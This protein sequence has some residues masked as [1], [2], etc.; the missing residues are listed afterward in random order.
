MLIKEDYPFWR[1][2]H[3]NGFVSANWNWPLT[4]QAAFI[5]GT[6]ECRATT[7]NIVDNKSFNMV[8]MFLSTSDNSIKKTS[9][10][11]TVSPPP[12]HR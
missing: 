5:T 10:L 7:Y 3:E 1:G 6:R 11:V 9:T 8:G 4:K 2:V 12:I